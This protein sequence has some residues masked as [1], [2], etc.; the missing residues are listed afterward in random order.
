MCCK[1]FSKFIN[2]IKNCLKREDNEVAI[3]KILPSGTKPH[4]SSNNVLRVPN[5]SSPK[6]LD[7]YVLMYSGM[8]EKI[9]HKKMKNSNKGR[10]RLSIVKI[11]CGSNSIHRA[12]MSSPIS[13]LKDG[14]AALT[15]NSVY[16]LT[17]KDENQKPTTAIVSKGCW[18][19]YYWNHPNAAVRMSFRVG[20][21]GIAITIILTFKYQFLYIIKLILEWIQSLITVI[22]ENINIL[23]NTQQQ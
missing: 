4:P 10:K 16:L 18:W 22:I 17:A 14:F 2:C 11:K 15:P 12:F 20:I 19:I 23:N 21:I 1:C 8:Y 6:E 13:G 7:E 9:F 3:L 5:I